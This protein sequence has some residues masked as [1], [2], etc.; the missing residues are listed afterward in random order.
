MT[1]VDDATGLTVTVTDQGP[2][3]G[4]VS[5]DPAADMLDVGDDD[6][7]VDPDVALAVLTGLVDECEIHAG[8]GGTTVTLHWPLPPR[9]VGAHGP[10]AT[11]V[12]QS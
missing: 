4:P 12:S 3:A 10:G 2:A 11:A 9:A 6:D 8:E 5:D 7:L 1:V